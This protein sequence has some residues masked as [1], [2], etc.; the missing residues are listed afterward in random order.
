[1][2]YFNFKKK[3]RRKC[4]HKLLLGSAVEEKLSGH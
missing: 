1:M 3:T 4:S 2:R